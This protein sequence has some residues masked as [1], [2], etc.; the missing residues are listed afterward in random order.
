MAWYVHAY[1]YFW[2]VISPEFGQVSHYKNSF[3]TD[4]NVEE[5]LCAKSNSPTAKITCAEQNFPK[6]YYYNV[7]GCE[8]D[9]VFMFTDE[10]KMYCPDHREYQLVRNIC[11]IC[12]EEIS[13]ST[14]W[15]RNCC[16]NTSCGFN[17]VAKKWHSTED[18]YAPSSRTVGHNVEEANTR[19]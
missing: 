17:V 2:T 6:L 1:N 13:S 5:K 11:C 14:A 9:W 19:F 8:G 3:R 16:R 7:C 4:D 18:L 10:Y 12:C 15:C